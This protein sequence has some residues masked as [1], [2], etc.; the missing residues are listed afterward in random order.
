VVVSLS[1]V[2]L[3]VV[4]RRERETPWSS[5][6]FPYLG[7]IIGGWALTWAAVELQM[8][9]RLLDTVSL[10]GDQWLVVLGLSLVAPLLVAADKFVTMRRQR[11]A[12][13]AAAKADS[14]VPRPR[15]PISAA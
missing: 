10:T 7:W 2:N 1:A 5:P 14:A 12:A 3:G 6:I 8:L 4:L 9:Q 15:E 13:P 11:A